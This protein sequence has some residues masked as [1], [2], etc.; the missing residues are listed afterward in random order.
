MID[1][2]ISELLVI[3]RHLEA[4]RGPNKDKNR[5]PGGSENR[6][7]RGLRVLPVLVFRVDQELIGEK[8]NLPTKHVLW[9][10]A[11]RDEP[12]CLSYIKLVG[13]NR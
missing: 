3:T 9:R 4:G 11:A 8:K 10:R 2:L 5:R 7:G 12:P 1:V 6:R 13:P